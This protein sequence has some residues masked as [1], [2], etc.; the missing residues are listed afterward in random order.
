MKDIFGFAEIRR[1]KK[2]S[3]SFPSINIFGCRR[4]VRVDRI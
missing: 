3:I 2:S 1:D 4:D